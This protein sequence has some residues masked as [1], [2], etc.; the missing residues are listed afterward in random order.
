MEFGWGSTLTGLLTRGGKVLRE[1]RDLHKH[2]E[3][4]NG[5]FLALIR[6]ELQLGLVP[7]IIERGAGTAAELQ[8][9]SAK[10]S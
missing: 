6:T 7:Y 2:T 9:L 10:E 1:R 3:P 8:K 5:E 4:V